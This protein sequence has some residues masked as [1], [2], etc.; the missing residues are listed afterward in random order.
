MTPPPGPRPALRRT[1]D[2]PARALVG[3]LVLTGAA[4]PAWPA[5]A[6]TPATAA[7]PPPATA[8]PDAAAL[9]R[10]SDWL[11]PAD[12]SADVTRLPPGERAALVSI[13]RAARLMDALY[14]RQVWAGNA[15]LTL[16]LAR[17]RTPLGRERLRALWQNKGPWLRLDGDRPFIPGV[18]PKPPAGTFYPPDATKAELASWMQGL[19]AEGRARAAGFFTVIRRGTDGKLAIVPYSVA[20]QPELAQVAAWLR[21]A[22]A[23]TAQPSLRRYLEAR[24]AAFLSN[25]YYASDVAWMQLDGSIEP[26]HRPVRGVRGRLVQR[27]GRVRGV[28]HRARRRRDG[29]AGPLRARAAGPGEPAAHR[30][31][32]AQ[33][34][35]SA[36]LA[37]IRV[38]DSIFGAGDANHGVQTAAFNLPND[39]R[40]R[41]REGHQAGHAEERAGGEVSR[42]CCCP[43]RSVVLAG[44]AA[45]RRPLRR[46]LHAHPD[47]RADARAGP[48]PG[49]RPVGGARRRCGRSCRRPTAPS[50]RRR[51]TSPGCS[52]CSTLI[53]QGVLPKLARA[54]ALHDVPGVGVP[55]DP[56]RHERG[57][58]PGGGAAAQHAARR[59]RV[60][61][62]AGR[63]VLGGPGEDEGDGARADRAS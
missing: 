26:T 14:M 16:E 38:V 36:P 35:A 2:G 30:A 6:A 55:L 24:A 5:P 50:R 10:L 11:A 48:A 57:A 18:G 56:L 13:L 61:R 12:L 52:R 22:A 39:E 19:P 44:R 40:D 27:Q 45:P 20:Y 1:L 47:A 62:G 17:D 49:H 63:H 51:R 53:D 42:W 31:R 3:A 58:R 25:D 59:R 54:A 46:V 41:A 29:A 8:V 7:A 4:W 32:A 34:A 33:R 37:P 15:A 60:R 43:S 9:K 21:D 28:R 23:K